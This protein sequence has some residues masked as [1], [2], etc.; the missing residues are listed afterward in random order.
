M[1]ALRGIRLSQLLTLPPRNAEIAERR[2]ERLLHDVR[3]LV[4]I[5]DHP[6]NEGPELIPG[7]TQSGR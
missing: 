2:E 7:S 1:A 4:G 5:G 3:R 6:D